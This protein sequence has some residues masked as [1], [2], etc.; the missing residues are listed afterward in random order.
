MVDVVLFELEAVLFDAQPLRRASLRD[1][2]DAHGIDLPADI[3][4]T[5][6][7]AV[8]TSVLAAIAAAGATGDDVTVDL[9]T[10]DAEQAFSRRLSL[11]G[12]VL[13][14]GVRQFIDRA[15]GEARLAVVTR[16]TRSDA[17]A[18]LRL[19]GFEGAFSCVVTADDVIDPK[20]SP[21]AIHLALDRLARQRPISRAAVLALEDG[22]DG[23]HAA[24]AAR[25]R[26][27]AVGSVPPHVAIEADAYVG[28]LGE[29]TPASLDTL[30]L[31]GRERVQ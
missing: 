19:S 8:R 23:I 25:I 27:I 30:S 14:P 11:S 13:Q 22:A 17:D 29:H 6:S 4:L 28:S 18:M 9:I 5:F 1:A 12:V 10:R 16:T 15:A 2:C 7:S 24:R 3:E 26:C 31:P 20:P 21:A